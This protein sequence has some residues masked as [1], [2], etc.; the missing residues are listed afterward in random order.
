LCCGENSKQRVDRLVKE[1]KIPRQAIIEAEKFWQT[2]LCE[3]LVGP[4]ESKI[5]VTLSDLYHAIVD[6]RVWRHPERIK[7]ALKSVVEIV[8]SRIDPAYEVWICRWRED[9]KEITAI[10]V[11]APNR[12]LKTFHIIDD[13]R[14]KRFKKGVKVL[15]SK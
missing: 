9:G 13:K 1:G 6:P 3:P 2:N 4:R 10:A 12:T 15:W 7:T 5:T 8:E 14:I 11:I